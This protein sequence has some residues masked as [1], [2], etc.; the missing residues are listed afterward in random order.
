ML[1]LIQMGTAHAV[2]KNTEINKYE[3]WTV[4]GT[5]LDP[6][7]IEQDDIFDDEW[8]ALDCLEDADGEFEAFFDLSEMIDEDTICEYND[9]EFNRWLDAFEELINIEHG[10]D[11]E[12]PDPDEFRI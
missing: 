7:L 4:A 1:K 3:L 11:F 6:K 12:L 8:D 2:Y 9:D 10:A 5:K